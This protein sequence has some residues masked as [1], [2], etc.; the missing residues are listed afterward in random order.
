MYLSN[1]AKEAHQLYVD[2]CFHRKWLQHN[3][4][5][6]MVTIGKCCALTVIA[7]QAPVNYVELLH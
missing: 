5:M 7:A 2:H 1:V 4:W 6:C 3:T